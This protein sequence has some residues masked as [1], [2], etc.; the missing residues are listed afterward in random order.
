MKKKSETEREK[1]TELK[2]IIKK[3]VEHT[4]TETTENRINK[5][6]S[7]FFEETVDRLLAK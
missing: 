6:E 1:K 2:D 4:E 7:R 5:A 3:R